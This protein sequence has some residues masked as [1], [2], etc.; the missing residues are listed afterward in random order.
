M[1][2]ITK[3]HLV[4]ACHWAIKARSN[5]LPTPLDG[6]ARYYDQGTWDCGTAC[7]IHGAAH[8]I[9]KGFPAYCRPT[10]GDYV[11]LPEDVREEVL[12]LLGESDT[13]PEHIL[14]LLEREGLL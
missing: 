2:P 8:I 5:Q 7:C 13:E 10:Y 4:E 12:I 11:E 3:D 14:N 9:A 6:H 1:Q